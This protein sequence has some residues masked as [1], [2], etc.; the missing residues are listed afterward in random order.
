MKTMKTIKEF[1]SDGM[2][3]LECSFDEK[4]VDPVVGQTSFRV[5]VCPTESKRDAMQAKLNN[6]AGE[7]NCVAISEGEFEA[8]E[9]LEADEQASVL[10]SLLIIRRH[11]DPCAQMDALRRREG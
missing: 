3:W 7:T 1:K 2:R 10:N 11:C 6:S 5:L 9:K 8:V 4:D